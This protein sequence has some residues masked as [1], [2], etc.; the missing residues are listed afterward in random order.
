MFHMSQLFLLATT[1]TLQKNQ[2]VHF[3]SLNMYWCHLVVGSVLC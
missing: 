2:C 3:V 1:L